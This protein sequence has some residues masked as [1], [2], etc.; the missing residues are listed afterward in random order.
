V[1]VTDELMVCVDCVL[2]IANGCDTVE[3]ER[4]AASMRDCGSLFVG[5]DSK[6]DEF[7]WCACGCCGSSLGG[8]RHHVVKLGE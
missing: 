8:S 2:I 6:D 1:R 3:Q 7:S 5:D 4:H